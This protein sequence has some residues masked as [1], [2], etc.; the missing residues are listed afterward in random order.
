M[1]EVAFTVVGF[2]LLTVSA[3]AKIV[4]KHREIRQLEAEVRSLGGDYWKAWGKSVRGEEERE[5]RVLGSLVLW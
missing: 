2:G 5:D 3:L 1:Y 4:E